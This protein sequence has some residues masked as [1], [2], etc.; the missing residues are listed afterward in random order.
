MSINISKDE[1][2]Q[3]WFEELK[4]RIQG[5][6]IKAAIKVTAEL[7]LLYWQLGEEIILKQKE[8]E[9]GDAVINQLSNDLTAAF[10]GMKGF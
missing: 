1:A 8:S 5:S 6:Q 9:W 7:L 10:P 3:T 2:Y 4:T